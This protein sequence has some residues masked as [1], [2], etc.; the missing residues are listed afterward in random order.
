MLETATAGAA[1]Q[2]QENNIADRFNS[3]CGDNRGAISSNG[4]AC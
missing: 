4:K 1:K 2:A 3:N